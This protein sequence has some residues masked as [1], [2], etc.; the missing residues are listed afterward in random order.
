M[1]SSNTRS[2]GN[3]PSVAVHQP[4]NAPNGIDHEQPGGEQ[5]QH[6]TL[7]D[8]EQD[9]VAGPCELVT[10]ASEECPAGDGEE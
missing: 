8:S 9:E 1:L 4:D 10:E 2:I 7:G 3:P 6:T 5:P